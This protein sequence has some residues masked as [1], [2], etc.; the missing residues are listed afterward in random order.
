MERVSSIILGKLLTRVGKWWMVFY[1]TRLIGK[2]NQVEAVVAAIAGREARYTWS[3][4][5]WPSHFW[6][7]GSWIPLTGYH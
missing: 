1:R 2:P 6:H 3:P 5:T 4:K 7:T